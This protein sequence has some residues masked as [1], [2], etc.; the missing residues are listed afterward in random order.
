MSGRAVER[1]TDSEFVRP[2]SRV[3]TNPMVLGH[4][5]GALFFSGVH[6]WSLEGDTEA[7]C[8]VLLVANRLQPMTGPTALRFVG[9]PAMRSKGE[10]QRR[11]RTKVAGCD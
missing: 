10:I 7:N 8:Q 1:S 5:H 4:S 9:L 2:V 11:L 3:E 6:R